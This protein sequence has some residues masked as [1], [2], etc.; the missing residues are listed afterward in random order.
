[1]TDDTIVYLLIPLLDISK[2][3][4]LYTILYEYPTHIFAHVP[5]LS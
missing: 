5:E 1:M 2:F 3:S 4:Q